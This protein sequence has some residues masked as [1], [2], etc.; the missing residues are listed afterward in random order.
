MNNFVSNLYKTGL[1]VSSF[2]FTL[3]CG[4]VGTILGTIINIKVVKSLTKKERNKEV[5]KT[6]SKST[7][8]KLYLSHFLGV[9]LITSLP[10]IFIDRTNKNTSIANFIRICVYYLGISFVLQQITFV[11]P[12]M[13]ILGM[14][15]MMQLDLRCCKNGCERCHNY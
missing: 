12:T 15:T 10:L 11:P 7:M 3:G 6:V 9:A 1:P 8:A 14:D 13:V 4:I 2:N 5:F